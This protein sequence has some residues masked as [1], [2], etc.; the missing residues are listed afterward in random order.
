MKIVVLDGYTLNPGDNPWEPLSQLGECTVYDRT[1][2][3]QVIERAAQAECLFVNKTKLTAE[4]VNR[5]PRLRFIGVLATGVDVVDVQAAARRGIPV[6]NAPA[7]GADAVA[8]HV[9]ALLLELCRHVGEHDA[10]IRAG[11]WSASPDY[12]YWKTPQIDLKGKTLGLVGF[13]DIGRRVGEIGHAF[14]MS[15]LAH[16]RSRQ[17]APAYT[18]FAFV[19]WDSLLTASDVL[20]LHVPLTLSTRGLINRETLERMRDGALLINTARG[21]LVD[22]AAVAEALHSGRLGGAGFDVACAEPIAPESPLLHAPNCILTPHIAWAT[23]TARQR[24]M[25]ICA[26]NLKAFLAGKPV[27]VVNNQAPYAFCG[28]KG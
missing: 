16:V 17:T 3:E 23:L 27:N 13:G 4:I 12:C 20:S 10:S 11:E 14:G 6:C 25:Q 1:P 18:P 21:P 28:K 7:Y 5:L 22:E 9:F 2:P 26:D 24:L 8:Q 15:V 19:D